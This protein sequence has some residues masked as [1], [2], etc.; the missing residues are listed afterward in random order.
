MSDMRQAIER[1]EKGR[2]KKARKEKK[3]KEKKKKKKK[4]KKIELAHA[5]IRP[6][7]Q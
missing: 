3:R 2:E 1:R 7:K 5:R 4:K 6:N